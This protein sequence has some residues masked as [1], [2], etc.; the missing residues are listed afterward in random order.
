MFPVAAEAESRKR[1]HR[2]VLGTSLLLVSVIC[3]VFM[4]AIR[5]APNS[6]WTELFGT[7]F[8]ISDG[9]NIEHLLLLYAFSAGL[10]CLSIVLIAYEMSHKIANTGWVQLVFGGIVV[11]GIYR[12]H[13]SLAQVIWV[14]IALMAILLLMVS[15]P[16]FLS[17]L[18]GGSENRAVEPGLVNLRRPVAEAEV[19]AEFLKSDIGSPE[20]ERFRDVME[21]MVTAPD[22]KDDIQSQVRRAFFNIR[23]R[24]L[25]N[26]LPADT[27]WFE[28]EIR[29]QDLH[30]VHVFPRAQWR[31]L[32]LGDFGLRQISERMLEPSYRG[33]TTQAFQD[34]IDNLRRQLKK[35]DI[36]GAAILL[37]GQDPGGPFT[38]LDGNHRL[39][40]AL[41]VSPE[42]VERFRFYCGL[43]PRMAECCWYQTTVA[44]LARYGS[45]RMRYLANDPEKELVQLLQQGEEGPAEAWPGE[46]AGESANVRN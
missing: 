16:Y 37:I 1:D 20:F 18:F 17:V 23:H 35:D 8:G 32:A 25:W 36:S 21:Q 44:N 15:I 45:H 27:Q 10:Y 41:L 31:K 7:R 3:S 29:V 11:G 6:I 24:S 43:S 42:T 12:F 4:L 38:I 30:R 2:G 22:L 40:A 26:E 13:A 46:S 28:A 5:L 33:R 39:V 14:Q 19:I 9:N 34:K